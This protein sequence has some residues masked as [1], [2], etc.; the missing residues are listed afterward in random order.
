MYKRCKCEGGKRGERVLSTDLIKWSKPAPIISIVSKRSI[1]FKLYVCSKGLWEEVKK[2]VSVPHPT[3]PF[4][5]PEMY[6]CWRIWLHQQSW[7]LSWPYGGQDRPF[8]SS[9]GLFPSWS[10][11]WQRH[12]VLRLQHHA[13]W[14]PQYQH[15]MSLGRGASSSASHEW[16]RSNGQVRHALLSDGG[17]KVMAGDHKIK[18]SLHSFWHYCSW[19]ILV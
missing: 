9:S 12:A 18:Q 16:Q 5:H 11:P 4:Y 3:N 15:G 8:A 14:A 10:L 6:P 7:G 1:E 19:K 2:E 17:S 13:A